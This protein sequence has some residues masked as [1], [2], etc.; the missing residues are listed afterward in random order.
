MMGVGGG[1]V[2]MCN[3]TFNNITVISW[4]SVLL[5]EQ[6]GVPGKNYQPFANQTNFITYWW[7]E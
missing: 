5:G 3:A 1:R 7:I 4:R 2:M 6:T